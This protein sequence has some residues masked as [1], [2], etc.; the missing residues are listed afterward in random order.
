MQKKIGAEASEQNRTEIAES[1]SFAYLIMF[2][3]LVSSQSNFVCIGILSL[4]IVKTN[5]IAIFQW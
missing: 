3:K 4:L 1:R 5:S 2:I